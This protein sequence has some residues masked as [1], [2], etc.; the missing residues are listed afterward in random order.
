MARALLT[1]AGILAFSDWVAA[2]TTWRTS[3][4]FEALQPLKPT[5]RTAGR[6]ALILAWQDDLDVAK[7]KFIETTD[8][9]SQRGV[10]HGGQRR[11]GC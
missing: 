1:K 11:R 4:A 8:F 3:A 9:A 10:P 7:L 5:T 6:Q 2:T